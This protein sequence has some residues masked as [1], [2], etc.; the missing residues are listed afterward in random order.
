MTRIFGHDTAIDSFLRAM[1]GPRLHHGWLLTGPEGVGKASTAMALAT[2][3]LAEAAG[4]QP[5]GDGIGV[6]PDHPMARLIAAHSHPDLKRLERLPKDVKI[7]EKGRAEWGEETEL[8][9][10]ITVDQIRVLGASFATVPSMSRRRVVI[11]D[12]V[13]DLE[14]AGAN[15]LLKNLE[16]PPAGTIFLLV[17]HAPGR[18][19]PTIRSRCRVLR[20]ATLDDGAMTS[21]LNANLPEIDP[22]ERDALIQ[23]GQGSPGR[24]L[25]Y[26]GLDIGWIDSILAQLLRDGDAS[27]ALRV[28]LA[29][30]LAPK[31]AQARYEVF[32]Q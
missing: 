19:L 27:N 6:S 29:A 3:M 24:A 1:R 21:V 11:I 9:R 22:E 17:S 2:R 16:E 28:A 7:Q 12:A 10:S 30:K 15:A 18:L 23:A 26:A 20:F 25:H 14:R 32:L 13:D 4:P 31:A 8:A 5:D